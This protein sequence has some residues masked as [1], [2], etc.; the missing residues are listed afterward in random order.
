MTSL[1]RILLVDDNA[2]NVMIL[3]EILSEG[4][5]LNSAS[6]GEECLALAETFQ[7]DI[8]LLDIMMPGIDGYETC[9]R[10]RANPRLAETK[11]IMLSAKVSVSERIAGYDAGADD[12]VT[13]PFDE[14]EL[15][16][17]VRVFLRLHSAEAVN[18]ITQ[19]LNVRLKETN[20]VIS[21]AKLAAEEASNAKSMFLANMSHELRTPL[22]GVIGMACVLSDTDL[23]EMQQHCV[24]TICHSGD[25]LLGLID[26]ILDFSEADAGGGELE[27][28]EF[29][30]GELIRESF[31]HLAPNA[32]AKGLEFAFSLP[33][34]L[35]PVLV[36]DPV[37]LKQ[38]LL[39]LADNAIKFTDN[40][41]VAIQ[42]SGG[43][44]SGD[45]TAIRV[46]VS[47]TGI[48]LQ[49]AE[50]ETLFDCFTQV[51]AS[52]TR[53]HGGTGLGL[54]TCRQLIE[55]MGGEL[56]VE[57]RP[58]EGSCFWFSLNLSRPKAEREA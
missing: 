5:E 31:D 50:Q 9:R 34:D 56:G 8:V 52:S 30:F 20:E 15:Q 51:D 26:S 7:P 53:K 38:I 11:V 42:V 37:R 39:N 18:K 3:R 47:D 12:Y 40:G 36:G 44:D 10:L 16:S 6:S 48:G 21:E 33:A 35:P 54:A 14:N 22:N 49:P 25:T 58:N 28:I 57:S 32:E 2:M 13:K 29:D 17:K 41:K 23:N 46:D 19:E 55:L 1:S 45:T 4:H 27:N 43:S 24:K